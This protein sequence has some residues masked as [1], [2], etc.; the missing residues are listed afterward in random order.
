MKQVQAVIIGGGSAGLSAAVTL[1]KQGISDVLVIEKDEE[2]GG[3]LEQCIH[4]GFGLQ[5]FKEQLSGPAYAERFIKMAQEQNVKILLNTTVT[6]L[7]ADRTVEYVN[8]EEGVVQVQAGAV[9]LA[10]GCYE[11][12]RGGINITGTRPAGIYT[13]GQAQRYLNIDG[14][15][16]GKH[17][18]ILGSGDIGLIMARRMTLEGAKVIGVAELMPYSNGL[19]RNMKQCLED[20]NIPL[21]LSHTVSKVFGKD[22][23]ERIEVVAVDENRNPIAGSEQYF[24]VDTLLLS[25]GLIP[26]NHLA[27][28][29]GIVM[30]SS[31]KG[32]AVDD[33]YMTSAEG[34]FACGNGLHVHD[35]VDFVTLQAE[36]AAEGAAAYLKS[37][38]RK[39]SALHIR[40][41][42][43][44][45][46]CVPSQFYPEDP[47][48]KLTVYFR[49]RT[50]LDRGTLVIR[51]GEQIIRQVKKQKLLPSVMEEAVLTAKQM[52]GLTDDITIEITEEG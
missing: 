27:D 1:K 26:E 18:F 37:G 35:L 49:V 8:A 12:P 5:T 40:N 24:D 11:R 43:Q 41:G 23:L 25:V 4:N 2:P 31:T 52:A 6:K 32:P 51:S 30:D 15:M 29:A 28:H 22:R 45:S 9:I 21:L 7:T 13:A 20:F 50:P 42:N 38:K 44:I 10:V 16:V 19:P 36:R 14:Y 33:R 34:I 48:E 17:V 39:G 3:I 46:Y 47:A